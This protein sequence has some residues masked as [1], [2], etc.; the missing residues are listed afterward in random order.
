MRWDQHAIGA[1]NNGLTRSAPP[2]PPGV[3]RRLFLAVCPLLDS[4]AGWSD[5]YTRQEFRL[6]PLGLDVW[7]IKW[8]EGLRL[9]G[10]PSAP[11]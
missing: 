7:V 5:G 8:S 4:V 9:L 6:P 10:A 1:S 3:C 11:S 2:A